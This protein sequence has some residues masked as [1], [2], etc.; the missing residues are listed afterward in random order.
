MT[1]NKYYIYLAFVTLMW[2]LTPVTTAYFYNYM[3][4]TVYGALSAIISAVSFTAIAWRKRKLIDRKYLKVAVWTGLAFSIAVILQMI[5][6]QYTT[7][8]MYAFLGNTS[9]VVVPILM[10]VL[11]KRKLHSLSIVAGPLCLL[12]CF[13]I[14][15]LGPGNAIGIGEI[16]C[17]LAGVFFAFNIVGTG[18]YAKDLDVP[19][20]LMI[21]KWIHTITSVTVMLV[22]YFIRV[23][24]K[25]LEEITFRWKPGLLFWLIIHIL[26]HV[27]FCWGLRIKAAQNINAVVIAVTMPFSAVI[28]MVISALLGMETLTMKYII[29]GGIILVSVIMSGV[30][31]GRNKNQLYQEV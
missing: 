2:G 5:G 22:L 11:A 24:G 6:L 14:S 29:G 15:D 30:I 12:G 3:S 9:C 23:D 16:L 21:Q 26:I 8:S 19:V 13:I 27:S 7:P 4:G 31:E 18:E 20:Y 25:A 17:A 1:K 10:L 28:T